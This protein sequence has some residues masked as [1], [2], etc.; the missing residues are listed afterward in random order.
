M[1]HRFAEL[2]SE[3]PNVH[4][5]QPVQPY[6]VRSTEFDYSNFDYSEPLEVEAELKHKG[7]TRFASFICSVTQS[8]YARDVDRPE[9]EEDGAQYLTYIKKSLPP[10]EFDYSQATIQEEI[11]DLD[12]KSLENLPY[13][14]DGANYQWV[15][16]DGEGVAG[17]F[18]EQAKAWFY[19]PNEGSGKFGAMVSV[20]KKP[21]LAAIN[22]GQQQFLD[23]AGDGQLDLVILEGSPQGFY[24]R[25]ADQSWNNFTS[26]SSV[27]IVSWRDPNLKFIDLTGDG[28]A[29]ILTTEDSAFLWYPSLAEEGFG[30]AER[31]SQAL[32]EEKG[33]RLL[34]SDGTQSI[35]LADM[36]GDGITDLVRILNGEVCYWPNLGY[37]RFGAKVTMDSSP[38]FDS[39]DQ[40]NQRNIRL[41]DIDGSG[42]TDIIYLGRSGVRL[43]LQSIRQ[44]LEQAASTAP[45]PISGQSLLGYD[46]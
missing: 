36:S 35:Y 10:L 6:L 39:A 11:E 45:V 15:D 31:V 30:P 12:A 32:N 29:D 25:T 22:C 4:A 42:T 18:S 34:F 46:R 21:S 19:K 33:P 38:W 43:V 8:G 2:T 40:F 37:G 41:S 23:L 13:G 28:H 5:E 20:A 24:E 3:Q 26:F 27:P 9:I 7:S 16:L 1:F 44:P 17:I 14:L